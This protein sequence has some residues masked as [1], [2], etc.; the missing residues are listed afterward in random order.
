MFYDLWLFKSEEFEV[1]E[2]KW[3]Q[4]QTHIAFG[5]KSDRWEIE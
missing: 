3:T 5:K 4:E 1:V 2:P